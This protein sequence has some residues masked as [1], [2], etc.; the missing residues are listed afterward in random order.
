LTKRVFWCWKSPW[1]SG[2][3]LGNDFGDPTFLGKNINI[4]AG[5]SIESRYPVP[6]TTGIA[7]IGTGTGVGTLS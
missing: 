3:H 6:K 2:G 1:K 4:L 7:G 5:M